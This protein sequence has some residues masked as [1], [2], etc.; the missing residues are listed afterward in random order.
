[1]LNNMKVGTKLIGG[2]V[3]VA[4]IAVGI[5]ITGIVCQLSLANATAELYETATVPTGQLIG[6]T[7]SM[8]GLR[9]A[10][11]D[12]ILDSDKQKFAAKI[13]TLKDTLTRQSEEFGK[14]ILKENTKKDFENFKEERRDYEANL[15]RILSLVMAGKEKEAKDFLAESNYMK[16]A[17][18]VQEAFDKLRDDKLAF[19][20]DEMQQSSALAARASKIMI[21]ATLLGL[22][23]ALG[24]GWRLAQSITQ[25]V[26]RVG[27]VLEALA[28]G[29]LDQH[30]EANSQDEIGQ[31]ERS[32]SSTITSLTRT[33]SDIRTIA[34]EVASASQAISTTS[35]QVSKGA[36]SQAASAEEASSSMEEMVSNIK[37]NADNAQQ[38]DKIASKSA[39]DAQESGKSVLEAVTSMKEIASKISIVEEIARQTNLL[40]LNAAIEAARAGEHGKGF[41]VVAAE[42]RKLAE[43]SQRAAAEINQLSSTTVEVSTRAG[44]MLEKLVPDIQRTAELVQ[45]IS[46]S[47]K[48]QDTGAGQINQALIQLEKIIQQNAAASEEMASTTQELSSQS[49]QLVSVLAFFRTGGNGVTAK[50]RSAAPNPPQTQRGYVIRIGRSRGLLG[51]TRAQSFGGRGRRK[52]Q[53]Q[54]YL[55]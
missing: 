38:T 52:S 50:Q 11:R 24:L 8:Q 33:I 22:A 6:M 15:D 31:M 14:S 27:K 10:S 54:G 51:H 41:A 55:G 47:S 49:E 3:V 21:I 48:E 28:G 32:L 20:Q 46:A 30:L 23:V 13:D 39:S 42:V 16:A 1:M 7:E 29:D 34:G 43:R 44:G 4:L 40:A 5:G 45:E 35:I 12:A 18:A 53:T 2:F 25:P 17:A 19:S 26:L 37:Q 9:I 36:T